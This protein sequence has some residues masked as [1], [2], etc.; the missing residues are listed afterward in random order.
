MITGNFKLSQ[1]HCI[2]GVSEV[3]VEKHNLVL[4]GLYEKLISL[5]GSGT[6]TAYVNRMQ[7]GTGSLTP[8]VD[9]T[10]L[11][12]AINPIK[13]VTPTIDPGNHKVTF[14]ASLLSTEA[15]GFPIT[16]AGLLAGD[17]TLVCR[18]TFTARSKTAAYNFDFSW[19]VVVLTP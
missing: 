7:F 19:E 9:Q 2:T 11:Q 6:A 14:T 18:V 12:H 8:A 3:L 15:N 16:E 13:T 5:I 17:D 4:D 10:F 1:R